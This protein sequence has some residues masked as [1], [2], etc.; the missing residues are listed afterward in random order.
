VRISTATPPAP[1]VADVEPVVETMALAAAP[2]VDMARAANEA[3]QGEPSWWAEYRQVMHDPIMSRG[4][5]LS[6]AD[7]IS[8]P[9]TVARDLGGDEPV[10]DLAATARIVPTLSSPIADRWATWAKHVTLI[11][12]IGRSHWVL[13]EPEDM[14][15]SLRTG[16]P[17]G[18]AG[19][20]VV[21]SPFD[22]AAQKGTMVTL[23]LDGGH[24]VTVDSSR[25]LTG[26]RSGR[27]LSGEPYSETRT[28][29]R[30][31][32]V[33]GSGQHGDVEPHRHERSGDEG[34]RRGWWRSATRSVRGAGGRPAR[35][36]HRASDDGNAEASAQQDREIRQDP[37]S[38]APM[39]VARRG[40]N[41]L[42]TAD[43]TVNAD[44][45]LVEYGKWSDGRVAVGFGVPTSALNGEEPKYAN[46]F[47][48]QITFKRSESG[49]LA[50]EV[51]AAAMPVLAA[52]TAGTPDAGTILWLDPTPLIEEARDD[53]ASARGTMA[54][55]VGGTPATL[56]ERVN[57]V[58]ARAEAGLF[59]DAEM[60]VM[61]DPDDRDRMAE[62]MALNAVAAARDLAA[63]LDAPDVAD[64]VRREAQDAALA[65]L[66]ES[67]AELDGGALAAAIG[68]PT[69]VR[70]II[71]RVKRA[72]FG[73]PTSPAADDAPNLA[74]II[75]RVG[76]SPYLTAALPG[77]EQVW[78]YGL[79]SSRENPYAPHMRNDGAVGSKPGDFSGQEPD[80]SPCFPGGHNGCQCY[81]IVKVA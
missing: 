65:A 24:T 28:L 7:P 42:S 30:A 40:D 72:V 75:D 52:I 70:R 21:V 64:G 55:A 76:V 29:D 68:V 58:V 38:R 33:V 80:G 10:P 49:I 11:A 48:D 54:A 3:P 37:A 39:V 53:A 16:W 31:G 56:A 78:V 18:L 77:V 60:L 22:R 61:G 34:P 2:A 9:L 69:I 20:W 59:A 6:V 50:R 35:G 13:L 46:K 73:E 79:P 67:L 57:E 66:A 47:V 12:T 25:I 27:L 23:T 62:T 32:A 5:R 74:P 1:P 17:V 8:M 41:P 63:L 81:M 71:D 43:L 19:G 36:D 51:C 4:T 45:G 26:Q 44:G 15:P 14:P